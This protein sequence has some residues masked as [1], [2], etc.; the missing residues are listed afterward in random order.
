MKVSFIGTGRLGSAIA[1]SV[2]IRG[3]AKE[4]VMYDIL[5]EAA[6]AQ[7]ADMAHATALYNSTEVRF[8]SYSEMGGSSVVVVSAGKP[9]TPEMNRLDLL[10]TNAPVIRD[11]AH[12]VKEHAPDS[13]FLTLT[14][15]MDVMNYVA[16]RHLGWDRFRVV[17]SGGMLDSGRFRSALSQWTKTPAHRL[18]SW[19]LGEHGDSQVPVWSKVKIDGKAKSFAPED[20]TKIGA[21]IKAVA[22][23]VI[24]GKKA[25]EFGPAN[26]TASMVEAILKDQKVLMPS[27]VV[28]QG[29]YGLPEVSLGM[30]TVLG[31][32]GIVRIEPWELPSEEQDALKKSAQVLTDGCKEAMGI[33]QKT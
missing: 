31:K 32:R 8:G 20:R 26:L 16:Y 30:P 22:A 5:E 33:L 12:Q 28:V 9:R 17:G 4:I 7:A 13:V 2:A 29:E 21:D 24:R 6:K 1:Y 18:E 10:S 25:T 23:Q 15:P 11:I 3:M 19:V 27:S 14:N